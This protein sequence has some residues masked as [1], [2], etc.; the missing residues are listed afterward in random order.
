MP[1]DAKSPGPLRERGVTGLTIKKRGIRL[2][3]DELRR[4]LRIGRSAGD[5]AQATVIPDPAGRAADSARRRPHLTFS[6]SELSRPVLQ[7]PTIRRHR[8]NMLKVLASGEKFCAGR[9]RV[10]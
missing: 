6:P 8:Q 3:D 7:G 1:F 9:G 10:R 5:G 4:Q 2:D